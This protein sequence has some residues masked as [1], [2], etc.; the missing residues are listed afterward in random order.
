MASL[1]ASLTASIIVPD[2]YSL[3]IIIFMGALLTP[4]SR[5]LIGVG[6]KVLPSVEVALLT[7]IEP[8]LAPFWVWIL[9]NEKPH[10]TTLMGG[11]IIVSTLIVHAMMAYK[12]AKINDVRSD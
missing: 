12:E 2:S 1:L 8:L 5:A 6:T 7:I 4:L 11:A 3:G 10:I 9:L